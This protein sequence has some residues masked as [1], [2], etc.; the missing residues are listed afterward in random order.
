L[1]SCC[2]ASPLLIFTAVKDADSGINVAVP[3]GRTSDEVGTYYYPRTSYGSHGV[4][5]VFGLALIRVDCS[6]SFFESSL[7]LR[8]IHNVIPATAKE[9][10]IPAMAIHVAKVSV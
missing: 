8:A 6:S 9:A 4:F 3:H 5:G 7:V 2:Q 1:K 10:T